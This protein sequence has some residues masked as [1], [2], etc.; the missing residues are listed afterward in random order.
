MFSE[1]D[2]PP[3]SS[4]SET[5]EGRDDAFLRQVSAQCWVSAVICKSDGPLRSKFEIDE[6]KIYKLNGH[7]VVAICKYQNFPCM[8]RTGVVLLYK[9]IVTQTRARCCVNMHRFLIRNRT[10]IGGQHYRGGHDK[11]CVSSMLQGGGKQHRGSL[12]FGKMRFAP[13]SGQT[14]TRPSTS[15]LSFRNAAALCTQSGGGGDRGPGW[16]R[17]QQEKKDRSPL[18]FLGPIAVG[19]SVV[20]AKGKYV[21]G[22]LKL[23]KMSTLISMGISTAGYAMFY[24]WPFAVGMVGLIFVHECGHAVVMKHYGVPFSPMVFMP[25]MGAVIAMKDVPEDAFQEA[26]IA[27]GGPVVGTAGAI[28]LGAIGHSIDSNLLIA[29]CDF[30]LMINLF[31]LLPIGTLDGGRIGNA[32]SKYTLLAGLGAGGALI[33]TGTIANPIF[34]LIVGAGGYSTY[35]RFYGSAKDLPASYYKISGSQRTMIG[36]GYL[37]LVGLILLAMKFNAKRKVDPKYLEKMRDDPA[38]KEVYDANKRVR[39]ADTPSEAYEASIDLMVCT[40]AYET[41][42]LSDFERRMAVSNAIDGIRSNLDLQATIDDEFAVIGKNSNDYFERVEIR[43]AK[44]IDRSF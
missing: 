37:G 6:I 2:I 23:T 3:P 11:W 17:K 13:W 14:T 38:F 5:V 20:A 28:G 18:S 33:A 27:F 26:M 19:A 30:G 16:G 36:L 29:L 34:Y 25:F 7:R 8:K 35:Q 12:A 21:L 1:T 43:L 32:I 4:R 24:G 39:T 31:N 22:A 40:I 10:F 41:K 42:D 44:R 9:T 15:T